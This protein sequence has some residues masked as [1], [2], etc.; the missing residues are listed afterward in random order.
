V[1]DLGVRHV[2]VRLHPWEPEGHDDEEALVRALAERG[3]EIAFA[4]PQNRDLVRSPEL[5]KEAM[6]EIARRFTP[7]GRSFQIG[8]AINR[9][10]WGVWSAW[11][12]LELVDVATAAL[13]A[14]RPDVEILGPAVIDF[15]LHRTA[16]IVNLAR[17]VRRGVRFDALASLLYVDRRGAPE[18]RQLGLDTIGKVLLARA[19]AETGRT[20][21]SPRSWIT[22]VNWPLWEGPHSPAGRSVS[23]HP[24]TQA[25]YLARFYLLALGTGAVERVYWWQLVARGYGLAYRDDSGELVRRPS[26]DALA[27]LIREVDGATFL[28]PLDAPEGVYLYH[29]ERL[30]GGE[31][32]VGWATGDEPMTV[33]LPRPVNR[34]VNLGGDCWAPTDGPSIQV[35]RSPRYFHLMVL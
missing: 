30:D 32:V 22:E 12:N 6:D 14:E 25:A 18:N 28:G 31:T 7:Y 15:E 35:H 24:D 5:W 16:A 27:T 3:L 1:D 4:V 13:R 9:S 34:V 20:L 19:I 8:Q 23:V 10:K 17:F 29:F 2:L 33:H 26:F 21:T 11:E